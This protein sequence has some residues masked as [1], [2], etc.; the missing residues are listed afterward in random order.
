MNSNTVI[1]NENKAYELTISATINLMY[2]MYLKAGMDRY[3]GSGGVN[4]VSRLNFLRFQTGRSCCI[5][6]QDDLGNNNGDLVFRCGAGGNDNAQLTLNYAAT[7]TPLPINGVSQLKMSYLQSITSDVQNQLNNCV[8][9][10]DLSF[11]NNLMYV[12]SNS[13]VNGIYHT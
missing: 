1:S 4:T 9:F 11:N 5:S 7:T 10:G 12:N 3:D 2:G 13:Y 6:A 8:M